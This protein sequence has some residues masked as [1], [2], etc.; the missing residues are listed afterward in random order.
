[1]KSRTQALAERGSDTEQV[2]AEI[3][4]DK[5]REQFLRP[6]F[7][8]NLRANPPRSGDFATASDVAAN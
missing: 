1:L 6:S 7:A 4:V 3:A 5:A 8:G 2:D